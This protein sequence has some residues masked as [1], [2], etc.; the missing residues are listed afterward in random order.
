MTERDEADAIRDRIE[1]LEI[2]EH[3]LQQL[4]E[5]A[6]L[7]LKPAQPATSPDARNDN[8]SS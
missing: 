6:A 4:T 5:I 1:E 8:T 7:F 3:A 2:L